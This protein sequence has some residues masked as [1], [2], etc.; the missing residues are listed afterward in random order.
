MTEQ[1]TGRSG[2]ALALGFLL[3]S[4]GTLLLVSNILGFSLI[5]FWRQIFNWFGVYWP[6]LLIVWGIYKVYQRIVHPESARVGA[7]EI[8]LLI[9]IVL[10]GLT[11]HFTRKLMTGLPVQISLD[12]VLESIDSEI[13]FGP[14][15]SFDE[16]RRF[17]LASESGLLIENDRGSVTVK[18]WDESDL[19][20]HITKR[21]YRHSQEKASE[22]AEEIQPRFVS[23]EEGPAR[24]SLDMPS[25]ARETQTDLEVWIPRNTPLT[26]SNRRGPLRVS[27]IEAAV[28]IATAND[29]IEV[30]NIQGS[31]KVNGRRGPVRVEGIQGDVEA[32][33]RYGSLIIK[34][35][36]GNLIGETRNDSLIVE[37]VTGTARLV[38]RHS[39]IRAN[40]IGSDL[41]I[42]ATH[43]EVSAEN[44]GA[45]AFIETSYRPIFVKAV[46]GRLTIEAHSS[47]IE[48][49][50]I[51]GNLD[52]KTAH[53][54]VTAVG[55]EGGVTITS[56]QG[57]VRLDGIKGPAQ[58]EGSYQPIKVVDFLS[59]LKVRAEH[60]ALTISTPELGGELSLVT[61]YGD[62]KLTLPPA[63]SFRLEAKVTGGEIIASDFRQSN[64][65]E[66][67]EAEVREL[68]GLLGGGASPITIETSYG[69]I[70]VV[71]S[72]TQ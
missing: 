72:D 61:T 12:D 5:W 64:W 4:V 22:L 1:R 18:G 44:L 36:R 19:K 56:K 42:E 46:D 38:N 3:V 52:V 66:S 60:A 25:E 29:S 59:S 26:L 45:T 70:R 69:D 41:T 15:H 11:I 9:F 33:N 28:G 6:I 47:E 2:C 54:S 55:V 32:R 50:D 51:T 8:L 67:Q 68:R 13:S 58:V 7:G 14:A 62:V 17:E 43:T 21:V 31:L 49:R 30:S 34:D 48:V 23:P 65:E 71:E 10:A 16:E 57:A 35:V 39:R 53:R 27:G 20:I 40:Q 37:N 63:S 24:F